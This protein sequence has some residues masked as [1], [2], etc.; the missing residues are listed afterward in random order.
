[1]SESILNL[2]LQTPHF[3]ESL[4]WFFPPRFAARKEP[5]DPHEQNNLTITSQF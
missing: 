3:L 2:K 4:P 5:L 1:M